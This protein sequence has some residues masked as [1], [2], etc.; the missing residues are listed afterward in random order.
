[1]CDRA[2]VLR[3]LQH[4]FSAGAARQQA[5][6]FESLV[7]QAES[8]GLI[9][10]LA[11]L[12]ADRSRCLDDHSRLACEWARHAVESMAPVDSMAS[13]RKLLRER[14]R[15]DGVL[16]VLDALATRQV[17]NIAFCGAIYYRA[18]LTK[19]YG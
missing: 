15:L 5:G 9:L 4:A 3:E 13:R 8:T 10:T 7:A 19:K 14:S 6:H 12:L 11:A 1:M 17:C 16:A 18:L 2:N